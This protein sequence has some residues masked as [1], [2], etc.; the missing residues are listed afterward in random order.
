MSCFDK[1]HLNNDL[2]DTYYNPTRDI[3]PLRQP[4]TYGFK[5]I[6]FQP[7]K[8]YNVNIVHLSVDEQI[9]VISVWFVDRN[10]E[11]LFTDFSKRDSVELVNFPLRHAYSS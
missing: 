9:I 6:K 8:A 4:M 2:G 11:D 5:N 7:T 10:S 3:E 1:I